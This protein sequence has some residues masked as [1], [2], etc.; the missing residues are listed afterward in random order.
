MEHF[1]CINPND[2]NAAVTC[3]L[4]QESVANAVSKPVPII[5]FVQCVNLELMLY[6][7]STSPP[8]GVCLQGSLSAG[9]SLSTRVFRS[10]SASTKS[11]CKEISLCQ[12]LPVH[13]I[14]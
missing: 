9:E 2:T 5:G 12:S 1:R 13:T 3:A 8:V 7:L 10:W 14:V 6:R 11:T 4:V